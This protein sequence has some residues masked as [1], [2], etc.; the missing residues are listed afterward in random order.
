MQFVGK[1]MKDS[2]EIHTVPKTSELPKVTISTPGNIQFDNLPMRHFFDVKARLYFSI[3]K[4]CRQTLPFSRQWFGFKII[5]L[6]YR[7]NNFKLAFASRSTK[8]LDKRPG[9]KQR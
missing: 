7:N 4:V 5:Y 3:T 2:D 1:L 6:I 9:N 8:S